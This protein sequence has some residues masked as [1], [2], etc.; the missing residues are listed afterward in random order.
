MNF[1]HG[2]VVIHWIRTAHDA[3]KASIHYN[4]RD[5]KW[6]NII[7]NMLCLCIPN[8][9]HTFRVFMCKREDGGEL[10]ELI[11]KPTEWQPSHIHALFHPIYRLIFFSYKCRIKTMFEHHNDI[12]AKLGPILKIFFFSNENKFEIT[13]SDINFVP[14][15]QHFQDRDKL[16]IFS[17]GRANKKKLFNINQTSKEKSFNGANVRSSVNDFV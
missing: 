12:W 9:E 11:W 17:T 4:F 2:R 14:R 7:W 8:K 6:E 3:Q 13:F 15:N 16:I 10:I 1:I 5:T